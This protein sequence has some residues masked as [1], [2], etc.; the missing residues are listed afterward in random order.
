LERKLRGEPKEESP[1][2]RSL[3][4]MSKMLYCLLGA[5]YQKK[6]V[7]RSLGGLVSQRIEDLGINLDDLGKKLNYDEHQVMRLLNDKTQIDKTILKRLSKILNVPQNR[8]S[9][10]AE[11][12]KPTMIYSMETR[13]EPSV[14]WARFDQ[15][16]K[17]KIHKILKK[18][19]VSSI[20]DSLK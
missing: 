19:G 14:D 7:I 9:S 4:K 20:F 16:M 1:H 17:Q 5:R 15:S 18:N 13:R 10:L 8:L 12:S 3:K 11:I 2:L 6:E